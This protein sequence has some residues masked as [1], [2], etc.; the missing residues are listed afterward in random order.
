MRA[1]RR[2]MIAA[3]LAASLVGVGFGAPAAQALEG[4]LT[5]SPSQ[6][7]Q[8]NATVLAMAYANGV[9]YA[10]GSFTSVRPPG[11]PSGSNEVGRTYLA[12]FD[13]T[14]GAVVTS[15]NHMLANT[16]SSIPPVVYAT[17]VSPDGSRLYVGGDFNS[18]DGVNVQ[19][20]AAFDTLTGAL[21]TPWGPGVNGR[22]YA[23]T[24][25]ASTVYLGGSFTKSGYQARTE[26]GA[27]NAST[28]ALLPW[29]PQLAGSVSGVSTTV[30]ALATS[31][32]G[33]RVYLGGAFNS[34]N[35]ATSHALMAVD[36]RTGGNLAWPDGLIYS[37]SYVVG[38]ATDAGTLYVSGRDNVSPPPFRFEGTMALDQTTGRQ[39]WIDRCY[40]DTFALLVLNGTLFAGTHAH[41]CSAIGGFPESKPRRYTSVI[42][43]S[44]VNGSLLPFF[45]DTAGSASV[46][47][48]Q[49]N[50]RALATDGH[51][52]FV[53]GG[54]LTVN[55][56]A[57]QNLTR[58]Q[59]APDRTPPT[60]PYGQTTTTSTGAV[61][62]HWVASWDRDDHNLTYNVY[63]NYGTTPIY[64]VTA[65]S[66]FWS[67]PGMS[68]T[69][70]AVTSGQRV[71]YRITASDGVN[72]VS[73]LSTNTVTVTPPATSY[74]SAV[75]QDGAS[76][77]WRLG[78][79]VGSATAADATGHGLTGVVSG[80]VVFGVPGAVS[81]SPD[82]AGRLDG[83]A[84]LIASRAQ[85][86]NPQGFSLEL[87]FQ[88]QTAAGGELIGFGSSQNGSSTAD[89]RVIYMTN[90][91]QLVFG[92]T[93]LG[94]G[95]PMVAQT[96]TA[97]NDGLW[98]HLVATQ[99]SSGMTAYV[100]GV[101]AATNA[102]ALTAQQ[103]SGYWRVGGDALTKFPSAPS[104][105]YLAG[106]VDE[107]ATYTY[108]LSVGQVA[109][110]YT[111][112]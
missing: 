66:W 44:T 101:V 37:T 71:F 17:A 16:Y 105:S 56:T 9:V 82:T 4:P 92:V 25:T 48:S 34:V 12:A 6:M 38:M 104:S 76:S 61:T 47:G 5:A 93:P 57:Q 65:G 80:G 67:Q 8:T 74:A 41:D 22:V 52:L 54:W 109:R 85:L 19:H 23:I 89:D 43:E 42:A 95:Q 55:G 90:S 84:G 27:L 97:Y 39:K 75:L 2:L 3:V 64:T 20:V 26:V 10:G 81:S 24:A 108:G 30:F 58:F 110:H 102:A 73:S 111:L 11:S 32:D 15:F 51:Q 88:T 28:G 78:D 112:R 46:P 106:T 18:I 107:V 50:P 13:S 98:H 96:T 100:D 79:P 72:A 49:D 70:P 69:D 83:Q 87:W 40:G 53:G 45:P 35:G 21:V 86:T 59:A 103:Y 99:D 7:W 62:V 36:G 33:G 68:Y 14:T 29:A 63:R 77:Y 1:A 94:P 91:G 60:K 31:S